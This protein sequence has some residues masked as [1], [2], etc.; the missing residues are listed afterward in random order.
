[1]GIELVMHASIKEEF[2][3]KISPDLQL[4]SIAVFCQQP[5]FAYFSN[6]SR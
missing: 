3:N 4:R 1:M 6:K 5:N 2:F